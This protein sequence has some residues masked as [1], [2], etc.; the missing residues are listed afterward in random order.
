MTKDIE[1]L[2]SELNKLEPV[3]ENKLIAVNDF[4]SLVGFQLAY[5]SNYLP[6]LEYVVEYLKEDAIAGYANFGIMIDKMV[7]IKIDQL[8]RYHAHLNFIELSQTSKIDKSKLTASLSKLRI[9]QKLQMTVFFTTQMSVTRDQLLTQASTKY[10]PINKIITWSNFF[11]HFIDNPILHDIYLDSDTIDI[12]ERELFESKK[13][14]EMKRSKEYDYALAQKWCANTIISEKIMIDIPKYFI[15]PKLAWLEA[16]VGLNLAKVLCRNDKEAMA[17]VNEYTEKIIDYLTNN[18]VS[19]KKYAYRDNIDSSGP[20]PNLKKFFESDGYTFTILDNMS[21]LCEKEDEIFVVI[22]PSSLEFYVNPG[23]KFEQTFIDENGNEYKSNVPVYNDIFSIIEFSKLPSAFFVNHR[24]Q[25]CEPSNSMLLD[26]W[27]GFSKKI[28]DIIKKNNSVVGKI[29]IAYSGF[30]N[31][32]IIDALKNIKATSI[33]VL[34]AYG[35]LFAF[36]ELAKIAGFDLDAELWSINRLTIASILTSKLSP[37]SHILEKASDEDRH[38][39]RNKIEGR[40]VTN[41]ITDKLDKEIEELGESVNALLSEFQ[42]AYLNDIQKINYDIQQLLKS[43]LPV[44][45]INEKLNE[46]YDTLK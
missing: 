17:D 37:V 24:E 38:K 40:P 9:S 34:S 46:Y 16:M 10:D 33:Q 41:S 4:N 28:N 13:R 35:I 19:K 2:E 42:D 22:I 39:I 6:T 7:R 31:N 44:D 27:I 11:S 25:L 36:E 12:A 1:A 20:S 43:G 8:T 29:E 3:F 21:V 32:K 14:I 26:F 5:M 30:V 18:F 15:G 45:E 23:L